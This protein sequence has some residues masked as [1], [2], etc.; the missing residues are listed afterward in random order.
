MPLAVYGYLKSNIGCKS[1]HKSRKDEAGIIPYRN[2]Y[3]LPCSR[4]FRCYMDPD[5]LLYKRR[6]NCLYPDGACMG[7]EVPYTDYCKTENVG[8]EF[9]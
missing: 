8:G 2:G 5:Y 6:K 1:Y 3:L 9:L 7:E 4:Y